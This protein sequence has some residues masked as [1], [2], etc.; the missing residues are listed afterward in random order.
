VELERAAAAFARAGARRRRDAAY[1]ELRRL[2]RRTPALRSTAAPDVSFGALSPRELE[3]AA[4]L[5]ERLTNRQIAERLV[6]SPKTVENHVARIFE[7]LDVRS[8]VDVA[9]AYGRAARA[10]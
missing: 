6:L 9:R 7:K 4:L 3:V 2:G 1:R 5:H 10:D 8:R